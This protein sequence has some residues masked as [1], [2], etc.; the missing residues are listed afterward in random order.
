MAKYS[1]DQLR[2]LAS[3][4]HAMTDSGGNISYPIEDVEDL[5][6]AIHAVGRGGAEHDAIRRYIA[7]RAREMG[8]ADM[9]PDTWGS[10][11]SLREPS[12]AVQTRETVD[13][14]IRESVLADVDKRQRL[15]DVIAV[16]WEQESAEEVPF[17]GV[18]LRERFM[19][20]AFDGLERSVGRVAVNLG[21]DRARPVGRVV[22][23]DPRHPE[24]LFA[25]MK[26]ASIPDGDDLLQLADE[27]MLAPSVGYFVKSHS[28]YRVD[29]RTR[30]VEVRRAFLDH[31]GLVGT[32]AYSGARVLDVRDRA[33]MVRFAEMPDTPLLDEWQDDELLAWARWRVERNRT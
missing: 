20:G 11:G 30:T 26:I 17:Q 7:R 29:R 3:E 16:P 23:A 8:H 9:I 28:D 2:R 18:L 5:G 14:N 13:V 19:R 1:A 4:G 25:R 24:G 21:H 22:K 12:P 31:V 6:N 33:P 10:D 27:D 32:P 15:I